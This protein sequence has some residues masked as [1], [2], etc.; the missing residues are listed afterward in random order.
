MVHSKRTI[1]YKLVWILT[2]AVCIL[3]LLTVLS[4]WYINTDQSQEKFRAIVKHELGDSVQFQRVGV[5]F[6]LRPHLVFH[7]VT[8]NVPD[9]AHGSI[10]TASVYPQLW[11]LL[12]G[13]FR[14]AKFR[15]FS[16]LVTLSIKKD[17][18]SPGDDRK[19]LSLEVVKKD[20]AATL[21]V[22]RAISPDLIIEVKN[23]MLLRKDDHA[24]YKAQNIQG[25]LKLI[26]NGFDITVQGDVDRLGPSTV[27]GKFVVNGDH[28]GASEARIIVLDTTLVA[29]VE[30]TSAG[31][32][33][34]SVELSL[35]GNI[36]RKTVK[37]VS[38][39][40]NMPPEQTVRA[41]L[42][43][44][45]ARF[46]WKAESGFTLAG[47]ISIGNGP[48]I[49]FLAHKKNGDLF[50][51]R[52]SIQDEDSTATLTF[53][54]T[55]NVFDI[56]F[57][58][59]VNEKTL[60]RMFERSSFQRGWIRGNLRAHVRLDRPSE[61]SAQ[62][63]LEGSNIILSLG[64]KTPVK[65]DHA[66]LRADGKTLTIREGI[67][68]WKNSSI[69]VQ[70]VLQ[71]L[72]EGFRF[73]MDLAADSI[74]IEDILEALTSEP[75][76]LD[77][78]S[79]LKYP[80]LLGIIRVNSKTAS[81]GRFASTP[82]KAD[83]KLDQEG[84]HIMFIEAAVCN[85]SLPGGLSIAN[86]RVQLDLRPGSAQQQLESALACLQGSDKTRITG[87]FNLQSHLHT[88]QEGDAFVR[89]LQGWV[90]FT[91]RDGEIYQY[92]LLSRIFSAIN[93]T[94]LLKGKLP[95][96]RRTSF[97]YNTITIKGIIRDGKFFIREAAIDGATA[98]IAAQGEVDLADDK[99][100]IT[101]LVAP[102]K[103]VDF[104]VK[105]IP[106]VS[107][108]LGNT[109]ITI[110]VKVTGDRGDP[111]VTILSPT[112][113]GEGVIGIMKRTLQ[114]PFKVIE[115]ILPGKEKHERKLPEAAP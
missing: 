35:D 2:G 105:N 61:S 3:L 95:D 46:V 87:T 84:V 93:V 4:S 48:S 31:G 64:L 41:P 65:V 10:R 14:I 21:S 96:L 90:T 77:E 86:D 108:I 20:I 112:A 62:G 38:A 1:V 88:K 16:P 58:G 49:S 110:P 28:I 68:F 12:T 45:N 106:L 101:V 44:S 13:T 22:L 100:D 75:N 57:Q 39:A 92:P 17:Q 19:E 42:S 103:T 23:G 54:N 40:L 66:V 55:R 30:L 52:L 18:P 43:L 69:N 8:I 83:I 81:W 11:P 26:P 24:T 99:I 79:Q 47:M 71:A 102:F 104:I 6:F 115:P 33:L 34:R 56:A 53:R 78:E 67:F 98:N 107:N 111:S 91:A 109:L 94:D 7:Q 70:G 15:A 114:L 59:N 97:A 5:S 80:P 36:G 27:Q 76:D 113:I 60:N 25:R 50:V 9:A 72:K 51:P 32:M 29:N 63:S 85:V 74:K 89:R 37:F 73:D 82:I